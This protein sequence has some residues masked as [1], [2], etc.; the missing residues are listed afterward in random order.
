MTVAAQVCQAR[1]D[2]NRVLQRQMT[3]TDIHLYA[4]VVPGNTRV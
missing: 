3:D 2:L 4:S 1:I